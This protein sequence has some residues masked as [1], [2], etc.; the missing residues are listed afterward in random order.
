MQ[1]PKAPPAP[2]N[3]AIAEGQA[4]ARGRAISDAEAE[5]MALRGTESTALEGSQKLTF[6]NYEG[7]GDV[8]IQRRSGDSEET[9]YQQELALKGVETDNQTKYILAKRAGR[10]NLGF[11]RSVASEE[12][13]AD[14]TTTEKD[15][16][17]SRTKMFD[18]KLKDN[19]RKPFKHGGVDPASAAVASIA[20]KDTKKLIGRNSIGSAVSNANPI[21]ATKTLKKA[22]KKIF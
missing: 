15:T 14:P 11:G 19:W 5:R 18:E 10:E 12:D 8:N 16:V 20:M 1:K 21:T 13:I 4:R 2:A 3:P 22:I 7:S 6:D 17:G 9:R